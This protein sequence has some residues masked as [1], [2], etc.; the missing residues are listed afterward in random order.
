MRIIAGLIILALD[1][2]AIVGVVG[3]RRSTAAKILW[4][5]GILIFP[6]VGMLAW[7]AFGRERQPRLPPPSAGT[8]IE[9]PRSR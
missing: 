4:V 8:G 9:G 7:F 6:V 1:I 2:W 3:S 5:C